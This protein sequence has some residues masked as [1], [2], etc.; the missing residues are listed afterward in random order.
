M[1]L[2]YLGPYISLT[3]PH[4]ASLVSCD[5]MLKISFFQELIPPL[6]FRSHSCLSSMGG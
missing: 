2:E 6:F 3:N 4:Q 1:I 5:T